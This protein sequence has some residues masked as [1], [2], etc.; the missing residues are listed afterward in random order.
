MYQK[1]CYRTNDR[2]S[3]ACGKSYHAK[4][5]KTTNMV[6]LVSCQDC[7]NSIR[8]KNKTGEG[9]GKRISRDLEMI[10]ARK[11]E[12]KLSYEELVASLKA[13]GKL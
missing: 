11:D 4:N 7:I 9:E 10:E 13:D 2:T 12:E 8:Y 1:V 6:T 3:T 5:V